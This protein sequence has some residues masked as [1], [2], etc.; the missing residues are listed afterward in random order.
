MCTC[1][2]PSFIDLFVLFLKISLALAAVRI[3]LS[4]VE[5]CL[6][7]AADAVEAAQSR[8]EEARV[9]E[10]LDGTEALVEPFHDEFNGEEDLDVEDFENGVGADQDGQTVKVSEQI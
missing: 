1:N 8:R 7:L 3:I 9:L 10:C 6:L 5:R 2:I 4:V